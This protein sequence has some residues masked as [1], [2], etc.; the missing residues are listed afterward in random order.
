M[1]VSDTPSPPCKTPTKSVECSGRQKERRVEQEKLRKV[2]TLGE[3]GEDVDDLSAWVS[4]NKKAEERAKAEAR[5]KAAKVAKQLEEQVS[6][7][8]SDGSKGGQSMREDYSR[9]G[10]LMWNMGNGIWEGEISQRER[11][12]GIVQA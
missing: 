5:A 9:G 12:H 2:K 6:P 1:H 7:L 3:A 10:L 4:R 11:K 8:F